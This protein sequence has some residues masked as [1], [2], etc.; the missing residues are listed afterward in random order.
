M[1][2]IM[3]EVA[4]GPYANRFV[5]IPEQVQDAYRLYRPTPLIRAR[6]LERGL[7]TPAQIYFKCEGVSSVGSHKPNTAIPQAYYNK[8]AGTKRLATETGAGQWGSVVAFAAALFDLEA[9]VYMV[10][11]SY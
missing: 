7:D 6:R 11:V 3:Q 2:I 9:K 5:D 8:K 4:V 1:D 10:N